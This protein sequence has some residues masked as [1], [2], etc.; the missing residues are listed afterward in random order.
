MKNEKIISYWAKALFLTQK[1]K[2]EREKEKI[3]EKLTKIL[4][5]SKKRYLLKKIQERV[6]RVF[7]RENRAE[8]I[9]ARNFD[10]SYIAKIK[11][12]LAEYLEKDME[13][14]IKVDKDLIAGFRA[15]TGSVLIRAS[16][17][18]FLADLKT[19]ITSS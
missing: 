14:K 13:T 7:E 8:L 11:K 17:K 10:H 12:K 5:K 9:L 6:E 4:K 1:N 3:L 15:K 2:P 18:D 16:F 19:K